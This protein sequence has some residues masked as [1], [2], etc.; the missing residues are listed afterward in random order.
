MASPPR[1]PGQSSGPCSEDGIPVVVF[2]VLHNGDTGE[3]SQAVR[4]LGQACQD[5]GFFLV[6]NHG[7][8][9]ALWRAMMDACKKLLTLPPEQKQVHMDVGPMDPV[10]HDRGERRRSAGKGGDRPDGATLEWAA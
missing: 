10:R 8:P 6:T 2:A 3:R 7:V 4:H 1:S 5:W 9:E